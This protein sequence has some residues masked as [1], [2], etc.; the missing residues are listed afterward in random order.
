MGD[1]M[2]NQFSIERYE[3][4]G[5]SRWGYGILENGVREEGFFSENLGN[6]ILNYEQERAGWKDVKRNCEVFPFVEFGSENAI[7]YSDTNLK[8]RAIKSFWNRTGIE[9]TIEEFDGLVCDSV[10]KKT[11]NKGTKLREKVGI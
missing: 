10:I 7:E 9:L 4:V 2:S 6:G 3:N 11:K 5:D 1:D 8:K